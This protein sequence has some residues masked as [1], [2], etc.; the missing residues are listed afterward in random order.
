[1]TE[2][3]LWRGLAAR[4]LH[5]DSLDIVVTELGAQLVSL[6]R[7]GDDINPFWQPPWSA[8]EPQKAG[9]AYGPPGEA[10]LLGCICGWNLCLD[11]FGLPALGDGGRPLHG[12]A[13]VLPW[14]LRSE[15]DALLADVSLPAA[16]L[17]L[18]RRYQVVGSRL[19]VET[20][21]LPMD[22][23][24]HTID[25]CEHLTLGD[26]ML[27]GCRVEA[28]VD[29][30]WLHPDPGAHAA[31]RF[32]DQQPG[33]AVDAHQALAYPRADEPAAGDIV[34]CRLG[35]GRFRVR[36][37]SLDRCLTVTFDVG[38]FPWLCLWTEHQARD[39][40]P[41]GGAC[42]SRG[43]EF[44]SKPFPESFAP[45]GRSPTW[46]GRPTLCTVP[47]EGLTTTISLDWE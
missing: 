3:C 13:G 37:E 33:D 23:V 24:P 12:E 47:A 31:T 44:S 25:W 10:P 5:T 1:M 7:S 39:S 17:D 27:D 29:G 36:N 19:V 20:E 4:R 34:A 42:R 35:S 21:V 11:R 6:T 8:T 16:Q 41:W 30:A 26:P 14:R 46:Q 28:E 32:P 45:E 9:C 2:P 40:A 15:G 43:M 22:G 18:Q 38:R